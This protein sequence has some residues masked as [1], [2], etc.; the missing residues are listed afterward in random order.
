MIPSGGRRRRG[1]VTMKDHRLFQRVKFV[2]TTDVE[3]N[4]IIHNSSLVDVS[5]RGALVAFADHLSPGQG[6]PCIVTIYLDHSHISLPFRGVTVH[7]RDNLTGIRFEH[8]DIES[9]IHLRRLIE[10][11]TANADRVRSEL[12]SFI[13]LE[14]T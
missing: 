14:E 6:L 11:N 1:E 3:I 7:S 4:G 13:G 10:L 9:M 8:I 12:N 5:L 2:T